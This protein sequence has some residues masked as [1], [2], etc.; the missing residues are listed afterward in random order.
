MLMDR[1]G[2]N[3]G[4]RWRGKVVNVMDPKKQGRFQVRVFGKQDDEALIPNRDLFWA[5][6]KVP[7]THGASLKGVG[8]SPVGVVPGSIVEGYYADTDGTILICDGTLLSAGTTKDRKSTRLN[9][10]HT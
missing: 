6:P 7:L 2:D 8:A 9:S 4:L 5:I 10:S 3:S 1:R